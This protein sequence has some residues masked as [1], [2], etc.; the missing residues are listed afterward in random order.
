MMN[1]PLLGQN[2]SQALGSS[3]NGTILGDCQLHD[4]LAPECAIETGRKPGTRTQGPLPAGLL[5]D[6]HM[7]HP[8]VPE[9]SEAL[10]VLQRHHPIPR[11]AGNCSECDRRAGRR[12]I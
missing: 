7:R 3:F 2:V 1:A 12:R 8:K 10:Y 9:P 5:P 6:N 4:S 11:I